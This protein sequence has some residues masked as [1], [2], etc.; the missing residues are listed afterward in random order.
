MCDRSNGNDFV[1]TIER[2]LRDIDVLVVVI[3]R[4]WTTMTD[5]GGKRRLDKLDDYVRL[6]VVTALKRDIR[7]VPV[8][9]R[10]CVYALS[11]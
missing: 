1:K 7:V 5:E 2:A 4:R 10:R 3:G 8:A 11:R 9:D 6:E